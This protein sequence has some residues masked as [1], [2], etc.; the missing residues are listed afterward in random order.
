MSD[1][2]ILLT[3]S[4]GFVGR[5]VLRALTATGATADLRLLVHRA[6]PEPVAVPAERLR[7]DLA[8]PSSLNGMCDGVDTVLHLAGIV[9]D[10]PE[11]C[12]AVNARGTEALVALAYAAGVRRFLY[13]SNA[14]VYGYAVHRQ[15]TE[16]DAVVRPATPVSRSRAR[17]ERAVLDAGGLVLRPLF[18]Y[19]TGDTHFVPVVVRALRRAP[20]LVSGG[21]ARLSLIAVDD[22]A[23]AITA[24]VRMPAT[25]WR[26]GAYHATDGVPIRFRE[27]AEVLAQGFGLHVP[28]RTLPYLAARMLLRARG[29]RL[30]AARTWTASAA[31]RLFL[32]AR[33]HSYDATRLR[34][35]TAWAPGAAFPARLPEYLPWY[36]E[37]LRRTEPEHA[38]A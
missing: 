19:G 13:L 33:D 10:D 25:A 20:F 21:R 6:E 4:T 22:L 3:G 32:V 29:A 12:D 16:G 14:A 23:A 30:L 36:R 5:T 8:E 34:E 9:S 1:G 38:R 18:V 35:L 15:A 7:G 2:R 17:A 28:A 26:P 37:Y 24:L 11:R 27:L 31:H